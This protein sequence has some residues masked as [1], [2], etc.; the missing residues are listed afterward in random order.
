[1]SYENLRYFA[2]TWV[3]IALFAI[4]FAMLLFIFRR[5]S[6]KKYTDAA[7]IPL[8]APEH[9]EADANPDTNADRAASA[10]GAARKD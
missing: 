4:F 1:M 10:G 2:D 5:G 9:L 7:R 8:E 3:L 6:T